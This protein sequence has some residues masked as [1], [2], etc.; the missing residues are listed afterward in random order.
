MRSAWASI[1]EVRA[2]EVYR[3]RFWSSGP[4][5]YRRRSVTVRGTRKQAEQKRAELMLAHSE[6]APCP[7]VGEAWEQWCLPTW[8]RMVSDGDLA[9]QT[10][11]MRRSA[12]RRHIAPTWADVPCDAVRPLAVQQWITSLNLSQAKI[13]T[14]VMRAVMDYAV[15]YEHVE[16]NPM[17]ER[18]VMPSKSSIERRDAGVWSLAELGEVW[19][20]VHGQ[21][22]EA[23]FLLAGFGGLRVGESLGV[24]AS[25][26]S[27]LEMGGTTLAMVSVERQVMNAGGRVSDV[28]KNEQS[29]RTVAVPGRAGARLLEIAAGGGWLSGDGLGGPN[30]QQRLNAAWSDALG[31]VDASLRHPF[32][33]LRNSWQTNMRWSLRLP[34]WLI[35]PMMGHRLQGVTGQHYDRPDSMMFAEAVAD[36]YASNPYDRGWTWVS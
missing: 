27:A 25:D 14:L 29:R 32:H 5:G 8:E 11:A 7:T 36:A 6:D 15:R 17:R 3:I 23:A 31:G 22:F 24:M 10:L 34:P 2:G 1:T 4:D 21:W 20:A 28:L 35:E 33:N 19:H 26:V 16:H 12:W 18:Y 13:A 9:P 30:T